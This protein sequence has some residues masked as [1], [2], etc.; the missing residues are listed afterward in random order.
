MRISLSDSSSRWRHL[1][2]ANRGF[3]ENGAAIREI[4][5]FG[6]RSTSPTVDRRFLPHDRTEG[7]PFKK[8]MERKKNGSPTENRRSCF[9]TWQSR[10]RKSSPRRGIDWR[11]WFSE[12]PYLF[13][14]RSSI[15]SSLVGAPTVR[16]NFVARDATGTWE[17]KS[18]HCDVTR[19]PSP[20]HR[21][22]SAANFPDELATREGEKRPEKRQREWLAPRAR[23]HGMAAAARRSWH[24]AITAR[25]T[26]CTLRRPLVRPKGIH[27]S[28]PSSYLRAGNGGISL[29]FFSRILRWRAFRL[30]ARC[31]LR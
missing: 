26:G 9:A 8:K 20:N 3:E 18:T 25:R 19:A 29:V 2:S 11:N 22:H 10:P 1:P 21:C 6:R 7:I 15:P 28:P 4:F 5:G 16:W 31:F 27:Q 12:N 13:F 24:C 30:L 23:P 14:A 17:K